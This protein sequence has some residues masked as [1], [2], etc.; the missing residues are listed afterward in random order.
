MGGYVSEWS[1]GCVR[2][3][4]HA[5]VRACVRARARV[6]VCVCVR[7]RVCACVRACVCGC[8]S[9]VLIFPHRLLPVS[10]LP[11]YHSITISGGVL[12][13]HRP[14]VAFVHLRVRSTY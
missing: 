14:P 12:V 3:C 9:L 13:W 5:C 1:S 11:V 10:L 4:V 7:A 2:A 8:V 6:C